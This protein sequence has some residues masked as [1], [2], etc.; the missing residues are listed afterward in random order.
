MR[1]RLQVFENRCANCETSFRTLHQAPH[2]YGVAAFVGS[3][4]RV[5]MAVADEDAVWAEAKTLLEQTS[6]GRLG[7][8]QRTL[9]F[10]HFFNRTVDEVEGHRLYM[11]GNIPC[12]KCGSFVRSSSRPIEPPEFVNVYAEHVTHRRWDALSPEEKQR[13]ADAALRDC[14]DALSGS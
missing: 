4:E 13:E 11:W 5:A 6:K 10:P 7:S 14:R 3:S 8:R 9:C 1:I 12:P 2:D